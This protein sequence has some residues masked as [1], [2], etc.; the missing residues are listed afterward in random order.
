[1]PTIHRE[2]PFRFFFYSRE[3][4]EPP[5]VHVREG[6]NK[7]KFWLETV[8]LAYSAGFSQHELNRIQRVVRSTRERFLEAWYAHHD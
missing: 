2:G 7:A 3:D 8:S 5:H 6:R 4:D 1:M